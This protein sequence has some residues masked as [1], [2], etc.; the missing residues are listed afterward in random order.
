MPSIMAARGAG[1]KKTDII[2]Q[3]VD[4]CTLSKASPPKPSS[5]AW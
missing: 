3:Y 5:K 1:H 4:Y 2:S